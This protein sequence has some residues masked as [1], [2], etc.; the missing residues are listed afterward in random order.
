VSRVF[1]LAAEAKLVLVV[2]PVNHEAA[3][4]C[5]ADFRELCER[6]LPPYQGGE[7]AAVFDGDGV[8]SVARARAGTQSPHDRVYL[9]AVLIGGCE[10]EA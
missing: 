7:L 5:W 3:R 4:R 8:C 6:R 10:M 1:E 9:R 2:P